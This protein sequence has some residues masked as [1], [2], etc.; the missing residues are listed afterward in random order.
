MSKEE[1]ER[2]KAQKQAEDFKFQQPSR[3]DIDHS[4]TETSRKR[5]R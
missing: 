5:R 2:K 4:K 1:E 3:E